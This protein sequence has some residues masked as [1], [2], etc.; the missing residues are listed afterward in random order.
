MES[1]HFTE[2]WF[3]TR[4]LQVFLAER[5]LYVLSAWLQFPINQDDFLLNIIRHA[6]QIH[7][8]Y[9]CV[10]FLSLYKYISC[11]F[12]FFE[13]FWALLIGGNF[14]F[15]NAVRH[16]ITQNLTSGTYLIFIVD[17]CPKIWSLTWL[18]ETKIKVLETELWWVCFLSV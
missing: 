11:L 13:W 16:P 2:H 12:F 3:F 8:F 18:D 4:C 5:Y 9:Q 14:S 6:Y 17:Q 15:L 1:T 7:S 10:L